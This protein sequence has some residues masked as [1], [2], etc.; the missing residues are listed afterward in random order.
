M[1]DIN[2]GFPSDSLPHTES[3]DYLSDSDLEDDELQLPHGD[4]NSASDT[5][6]RAPENPRP[7]PQS[8][9]QVESHRT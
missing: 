3:Y 9:S 5:P 1:Q 8:A 2:D 6:D 7:G 4:L